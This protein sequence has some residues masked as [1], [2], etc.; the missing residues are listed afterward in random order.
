M[1]RIQYVL[2]SNFGVGIC[3]GYREMADHSPQSVAEKKL[4]NILNPQYVFMAWSLLMHR[5]NLS[6]NLP[7]NHD[8]KD[9]LVYVNYGA[10]IQ[11]ITQ[12][13]I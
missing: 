8:F 13:S 12:I 4:Y 9:S 5:Q 2:S 3:S 11:H 6:S 1:V 7:F 10:M